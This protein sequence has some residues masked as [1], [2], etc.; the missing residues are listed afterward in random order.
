MLDEWWTE[1]AAR[2]V[3][4][5]AID[6]T[7]LDLISLT[8]DPEAMKRTAIVQPA[9]LAAEL[10]GW[11][12]LGPY[13]PEP[14]AVAGHS[15]GEYS[16]LVAAGVIN[17]SAAFQ[18]VA[19]RGRAMEAA[20]RASDGAM[21]AILGLSSAVVTAIAAKAAEGDVLV[22]AN[23]NAPTQHVLAGAAEAVARA[24]SLVLAESGRSTRLA[25]AGAFHSPLMAEAQ[26]QVA[27]AVAATPFEEPRCAVIP[28]VTGRATVNADELRDLLIRHIVE[29]VLWDETMQELAHLGVDHVLEIGPGRVLTGLAKRALPGVSRANLASPDAVPAALSPAF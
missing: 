17:A 10:A 16:A 15:L 28:N 8:H 22:I 7:G 21:L 26:S 6:V 13:E 29:P 14:V 3:I 12:T 11:A 4:Q 19:V 27:E 24:E 5:Q 9:L 23:S 18:I 20:A 25:V 1:A 2:S